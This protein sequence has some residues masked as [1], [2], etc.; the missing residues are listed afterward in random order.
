MTNRSVDIFDTDGDVEEG[1]RGREESAAFF[2]FLR[3]CT[4]T[5]QIAPSPK[6]HTSKDEEWPLFAKA[7]RDFA[8][9]Y[10]EEARR[11]AIRCLRIALIIHGMTE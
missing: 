6:P 9:A 1:K 5:P 7:L 2:A 4:I 8:D 11:E 3:G 10:T